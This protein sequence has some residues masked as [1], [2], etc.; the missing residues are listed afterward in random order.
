MRFFF[1]LLYT[2]LA[3]P[4]MWLVLRAAA[5]FSA[6]IRR[7]IRGRVDMMR[8]LGEQAAGLQP[9]IR[10]WFHASSLGEFEQA[11]PIIA[12]L[13]RRDPR[14][15]II[16]SFFSPSGYDHSRNYPLADVVTYLPFD[17]RRGAARFLDRVRPDVA[18]MVRYDIWPNHIWELHRR[19]IPVMIANATMRYN[20]LRLLPALRSFHRHV[21]DSMEAILTVSESDVEAFRRFRLRRP[22]LAAIGDTRYDQV[23]L[24]S[25]EARLRRV[26]P[27]AVLEG[28][29]V[30]V[31][32]STWPEDEEV[33]L[34]AF[35]RLEDRGDLLLV[36]V[37]H[38][39]T[40][41]HLEALEAAL[42]GRSSCL[43]FSA[44]GSFAGERVLIVDTI[45]ILPALY[46]SARVAYVGG[47]FRQGVHNVLEAAVYGIPVLFGPRHRNSGEPIRLV[48]E[49]GAFVVGDAAELHRILSHLLQ[50]DG[51]CQSAGR[52]A[53]AFVEAQVGATER[54]LARLE[55]YLKKV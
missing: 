20:S 48:E 9:G 25:E 50:D 49:G 38:E 35:D 2:G 17:T 22:V 55:G 32:G 10:I 1:S 33:L 12:A 41:E 53:K 54:I 16:A 4:C 8:R 30:V 29:R 11:K 40:V 36:L 13:K 37:P 23:M 45:G 42:L 26:L 43:R 21:Y 52:K 34:A 18:L 15:R 5:P 28:R 44:V 27:R 46:A 51:A 31:A 3:V 7:G 47:S 14:V 6:K 24:R 39:P 19:G